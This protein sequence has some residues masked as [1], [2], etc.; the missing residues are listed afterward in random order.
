MRN[1]FPNIR[2]LHWPIYTRAK[3]GKNAGLVDYDVYAFWQNGSSRMIVMKITLTANR[4]YGDSVKM[5]RLGPSI[6]DRGA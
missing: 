1:K 5:S 6:L 3:M 2:F 4:Q